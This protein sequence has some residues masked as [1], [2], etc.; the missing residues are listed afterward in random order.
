MYDEKYFKKVI[1]SINNIDSTDVLNFICN[2]LLSTDNKC[3]EHFMFFQQLQKLIID[4]PS[5][6]F[7]IEQGFIKRETKS[8]SDSDS[9]NAFELEYEYIYTYTFEI[10]DDKDYYYTNTNKK[11]VNIRIEEEIDGKDYCISL[12][13]K[14]GVIRIKHNININNNM[15]TCKILSKRDDQTVS[16][17]V[18]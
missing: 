3:I 14:Y 8:D 1:S 7:S 6:I 12:L 11:C 15:K 16:K 18:C 2:R 5:I 4:I 10:I 17:Y 13:A 9:C